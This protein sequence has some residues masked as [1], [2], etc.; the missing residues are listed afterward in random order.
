[1]LRIRTVLFIL[2]FAI[3]LPSFV[4]MLIAWGGFIE[5]T[6]IKETILIIVFFG[7]LLLMNKFKPKWMKD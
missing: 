4:L 3:W 5:L 2:G 1:M 6:T 7:S